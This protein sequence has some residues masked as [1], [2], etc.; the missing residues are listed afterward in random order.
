MHCACGRGRTDKEEL[1][2]QGEQGKLGRSSERGQGDQGTRGPEWWA[3]AAGRGGGDMGFLA[4]AMGNCK[5]QSQACR[6]GE[7]STK[8]LP[9]A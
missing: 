8:K 1:G 3:A 5:I 2:E 7:I 4:A 9:K 6:S